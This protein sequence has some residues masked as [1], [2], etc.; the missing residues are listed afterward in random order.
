M[1]SKRKSFIGLNIE[2]KNK[3]QK[4]FDYIPLNYEEVFY[5]FLPKNF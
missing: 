5:Y 4:I 3:I 2:E 1:I